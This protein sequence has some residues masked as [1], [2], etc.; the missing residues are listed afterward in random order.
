[1]GEAADPAGDGRPP[2]DAHKDEPRVGFGQLRGA[3]VGAVV[4]H[5]HVRA[6]HASVRAADSRRQRQHGPVRAASPRAAPLYLH[7]AA[8]AAQ[9]FALTESPR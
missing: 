1:M 7:T 5:G 2:P 9:T 4:A 6:D 8:G 3:G